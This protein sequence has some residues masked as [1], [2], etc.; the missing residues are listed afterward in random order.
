MNYECWSG[1]IFDL[2]GTIADTLPV[3]FA[4]FR[5]TIRAETGETWTNSEI[6][7]R[8]GP[9]E[10]GV[11]GELLGPARLDG[12]Y[13][14]FLDLYRREH[15]RCPAPFRGVRRLVERLREAGARCAIV[16][17]KGAD[18]AAITLERIG[19]EGAFERM[20]AG[21]AGGAIKADCMRRVLAEWDV[22]LDRVFSLGD[23]PY[24]VQA[25]RQAGIRPLG[26]AWA[27]TANRASLEEAGAEAVFGRVDE[28]AS[29]LAEGC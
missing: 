2:D 25:A 1:A 28:L 27:S 16:T 23:F 12:A 7:S 8:F 10:E 11:L 3:S 6:R 21:S 14:R 4:A 15:R 13:A 5:R 20:E 18:A 26:A 24:D 29:W 22:P 19:L 17:G 9:S